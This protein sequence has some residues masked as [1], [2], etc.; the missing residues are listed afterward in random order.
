MK[1]SVAPL[2]KQDM[3]ESV[4]YQVDEAPIDPHGDNAELLEAQITGIDATIKATHTNPGAL[5]EGDARATV[6][7]ECARCLRP[8]QSP[9]RARFSEQYYA[10]L[11]VETGAPMPEPPLDSKTIGSD[12][13]IDLTPLIREEVILAMPLAPLCRPDCKGLCPVCGKDL[14]ESPHQHEQGSDERWAALKALRVEEEEER[15]PPDDGM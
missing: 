12:F 6:A 11:H 7:L 1:V 2:L 9:V 14:N 8:I 3:G 10:T 13:R 15:T 5:I 4:E